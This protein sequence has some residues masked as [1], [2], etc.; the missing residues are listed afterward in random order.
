VERE[1][2][3]VKIVYENQFVAKMI[4]SGI[5][6][7][8]CQPTEWGKSISIYNKM[9]CTEYTFLSLCAAMLD[10]NIIR[11]GKLGKFLSGHKQSTCRSKICSTS[12][13]FLYNIN[14]I[15]NTFEFYRRIFFFFRI[16][17]FLVFVLF[18]IWKHLEII[19]CIK[20]IIVSRVKYFTFDL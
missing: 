9:I 6:V 8:S 13:T 10:I 7:Q 11:K 17:I 1:S 15:W 18:Q 16:R 3:R 14:I 20:L 4:F 19:I 12:K 2:K 5:S